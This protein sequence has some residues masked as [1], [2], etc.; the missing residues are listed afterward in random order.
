IA[1]GYS[2]TIDWGD[3][4]ATSDGTISAD[5]SGGYDVGGSHTFTHSGFYTLT[6]TVDDGNGALVGTAMTHASVV[7]LTPTVGLESHGP[8][9]S[10]TVGREFTGV[11]ATFTD[12]RTGAQAAD[13]TATIDWGDGTTSDGTISVDANGGFHVT[14]TH[15]FTDTGVAIGDFPF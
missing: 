6:I 4:S 13:F 8:H 12:S 15:T 7:S 11:V 5:P 2:A 10:T 14:G 9:V 3:N 1:G